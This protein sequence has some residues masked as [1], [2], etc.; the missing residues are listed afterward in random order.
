VTDA[1]GFYQ[2]TGVCSGD[3]VVEVNPT[4]LPAGTWFASP[5]NQGA[6]DATDSDGVDH[7]ASVTLPAD[8][9]TNLTIDFG[10]H[11][12]RA[13]SATKT[14][15]GKY[16]RRITWMLTKAVSPSSY[17]G[18]PGQ[19]LGTSTWTVTATKT[20][21]LNNYKRHRHHRRQQPEPVRRGLHGVRRDE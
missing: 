21:V 16:D 5:A 12:K 13:L 1:S 9:S 17:S 2:F 3:F 8:D 6:N 7:R 20:V 18:A 19:T 15:V 14:A 10:Y 4:T 11:Q